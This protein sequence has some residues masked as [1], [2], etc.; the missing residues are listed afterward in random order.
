MIQAKPT[1]SCLLPTP[2]GQLCLVANDEALLSVELVGDSRPTIP[3]AAS[4]SHHPIL[5]PACDELVAYF[6]G[7]LQHFTV[8]FTQV[9]TPFQREVWAALCTIPYGERRSYAWLAKEIGRPRAVRAV[10]AAN[11]RNPLAIIVPCHRVIGSS[12]A[13]TGYAGGLDMKRWLLTHELGM[14][15]ASTARA[16]PHA[17]DAAPRWTIAS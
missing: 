16:G 8:P 14:Q 17:S 10:G 7:Q 13:L 1:V 15:D 6:H 12:G 4:P 2:V 5:G 9:G 3:K 11:G